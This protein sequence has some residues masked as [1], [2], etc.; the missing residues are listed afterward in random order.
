M[1]N[2]KFS[3]SCIYKIV[4]KDTTITECY[5]GSTTDFK[6][7]KYKHKTSCNNVNCRKYNLKVYKFIREN[8][9]FNNFEFIK[10]KNYECCSKVEL[11]KEERKYIELNGCELNTQIPARNNKEWYIDNKEKIKE[12]NKKYRE[13]NLEKIKERQKKYYLDNKEKNNKKFKCDCGCVYQY[14]CKARHF[15]T[16]KHIKYLTTIINI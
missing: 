13:N 5:V 6:I 12:N 2:N 15:K 4:C 11:E 1:D 14:K 3:N 10:I 7:R 16:I 9:G 8:G